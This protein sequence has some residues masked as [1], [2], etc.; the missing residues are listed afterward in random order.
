[1]HYMSSRLFNLLATPLL[2]CLVFVGCCSAL[3]A[4]ENEEAEIDFN[5]HVK[6]ILSDRCYTCHGPDDENRQGGFRL[7]QRDSAIG[8]ADSGERPIVPGEAELSE[9][10][11]RIT[12]DDPYMRMPPPEAKISVSE[13]EIATLRKWID[14][15]AQYKRH[16]SFL[17]IDQP[18]LPQVKWADWVRNDIDRFVLANL[19]QQD[20]LPSPVASRET[21]IRR[22]TFDLTGLP[23]TVAEVDAFLAD[24]SDAAYER[25]VDRLLASPHYGERMAVDW[26]DLARYADTYGYQEDRY[27]ETWPWRDW[28]IEAFNANMPF[29]E[30]VTWQLAGDLL[31]DASDQQI[32]A[33]AFNR[34]H[35]QTSEGGSV[36]EE[37]RIEYVNDRVDTFGT[38]FLGL[39]VGCAR[40]HDHK[41]DE[42][43]QQD[44][45]QLSAFFNNI[46]ESGL[47]AYFASSTPTPALN[48][49]D[50]DQKQELRK[51]KAAQEQAENDLNQFAS[52]QQA[53]FENWLASID[54][55]SASS[56]SLTGLIG[57]F[58]WDQIDGSKVTNA[59]DSELDGQLSE[60]PQVVAGKV[61]NGLL[62]D[63]EDNF[64]TTVAGDLM[65]HDPF[66]ISL[67]IKTPDVKDRAVI[68]HRTRAS[69]DAGDRGY[70]LF[71]EDGK[72]S[73]M[74]A[75]FWPGNAL[76]INTRHTLPVDKWVQVTVTY[77]GSSRASGLQIYW[78]G[79]LADCEIV[80]DN[81]TRSI[82]YGGQYNAV[83][84]KDVEKIAHRLVVGQ[85]FRDRGFIGGMVDELKIFDR[86][87]TDLEVASLANDNELIAQIIAKG[88]TRTATQTEQLYQFYLANHNSEY[89]T[90]LE[91]LR[92]ARREH[93]D[94]LSQIPSIMVMQ[95]LP[96]K[97]PTYVLSRGAYDARADEV[98]AASPAS[99]P[100][101]AEDLP[102]NRLGLAEWLT[103]P[104]HPL[105]A[106]VTVNRFWQSLFGQGIVSTPLDFGSQGTLPSHP[107]LLDWLSKS[108]I[109]SGWDVKALMK[110]MVMS[111]TYRQTSDC[112]AEL[113]ASDPLNMLFARGPQQRLSAEMIRDTALATS[114]LLVDKI[115]GPPVKPYQPP[116]L[117]KEKGSATFERDEGDGSHRRSL[118]TFWKRTSPQP[119]MMTFDASD[120][121]VCVVQRQVTATPL[122]SLVLLNDPQYVE[123][124]RALA[125]RVMEGDV[126]QLSDRLEYAFRIVTSRIPTAAELKVLEQLYREQIQYFEEDRKRTEEFLS[127]GDHQPSDHL[128]ATELAAMTVVAETLLNLNETITKQ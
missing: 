112:S 100:E 53:A 63:G 23:P 12:S 95:E 26:L 17:P 28:V 58:S 35:R 44:Y 82:V 14:E 45:Y 6:P 97:R 101:M 75:H 125:E 31:P 69:I 72:L 66:S 77:D 86:Q 60:N 122:Q 99:L 81:L 107:E 37:Y 54:T 4:E 2:A 103:D 49:A 87:L 126:I 29:D 116:G 115:G 127:I 51:L 83:D 109:E 90:K 73:A 16:W 94:L 70:Q 96:T 59:A 8:A 71:I 108:F 88:E 62:L 79:R 11:R 111:A 65:R 50:G 5:F 128:N 85:R 84:K 93:G 102:R 67:W 78:D 21:L 1:M 27:R 113:R 104:A 39:T 22:L 105:M 7:D 10:I 57:D 76:K 33:T 106:R 91:T 34:L 98:F 121:E 25:L 117:W 123:A 18:Q 24:D 9:I 43:S 42:I 56:T 47:Y 19:E 114:G 61:G 46:D 119:A 89:I 38:A 80:R 124:A 20:L 55:L 74:I 110:R 15:G 64:N 92:E 30:F 40:C 41:Y 36:E 68:W 32:L 3:N 118:Y 120:R 48:L 52:E 13:E